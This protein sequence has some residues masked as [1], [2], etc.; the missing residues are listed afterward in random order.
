M[1]ELPASLKSSKPGDK[2][3]IKFIRGKEAKE[4]TVTLGERPDA[5]APPPP[6]RAPAEPPKPESR[7]GRLGISPGDATG[8]GMAID[9][10]SPDTPAAKAGIKAGDVLVK[11]D[12]TP[13]WK[14]SDL[15]NFMKK[16]RAGQK[17]DITILRAGEEKKYSVVL[18]ER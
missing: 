4:L 14:E 3:K 12:E 17:V 2:A 10:V 6:P 11:L 7:P 13:I 9:S 8:K 18:A 15:E 1:A 5:P 16:A